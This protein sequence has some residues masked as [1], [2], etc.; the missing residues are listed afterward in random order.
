MKKKI[1]W[2][3]GLVLVS[4]SAL[5]A[6]PSSVAQLESALEDA[7]MPVQTA[8]YKAKLQEKTN[9]YSMQMLGH[10]NNDDFSY[11]GEA[12]AKAYEEG[13]KACDD[14][15]VGKSV[16]VKAA[17]IVYC[18]MWRSTLQANAEADANYEDFASTPAGAQFVRAQ[19]ELEAAADE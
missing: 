3:I 11:V 19:A 7:A 14:W 4:L 9:D 8:E 12:Y 1:T 18:S 10:T 13:K 17:A 15:M 6:P 16:K 2:V 5:A